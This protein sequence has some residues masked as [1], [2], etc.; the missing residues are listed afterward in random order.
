MGRGK[1]EGR[2]WGKRA[3]LAGRWEFS[4]A[5]LLPV[6]RPPPPLVPPTLLLPFLLMS[7]PDSPAA[8]VRRAM[9]GTAA[10]VR[11]KPAPDMSADA[12]TAHLMA[13]SPTVRAGH[14]AVAVAASAMSETWACLDWRIARAEEE[15]AAPPRARADAVARAAP[16]LRRG[17]MEVEAMNSVGGRCERGRPGSLALWSTRACGRADRGA[18][19]CK[20][21]MCFA[22]ARF[23]NGERDSGPVTVGL[24]TSLHL[25]TAR[26]RPVACPH[27]RGRRLARLSLPP[28]QHTNTQAS[29]KLQNHG[30]RG[31]GRPLNECGGRRHRRPPP[32]RARRP[33]R[34]RSPPAHA[35]DMRGGRQL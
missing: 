33:A 3:A 16:P 4:L 6:L 32:A 27:A 19:S 13:G 22:R 10:L 35:R 18:R 29:P 7:M 9:M 1:R 34:R 26:S 21:E 12:A 8:A 2:G 23:R 5:L 15:G 25:S 11:R 20:C 14:R 24:F 31:P 30:T 17:G 28:Q